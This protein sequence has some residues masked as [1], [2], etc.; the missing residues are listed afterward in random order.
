MKKRKKT[1]PGRPTAT[2]GPPT[3]PVRFQSVTHQV[4]QTP[5][6]AVSF[7]VALDTDGRGWQ[8]ASDEAEAT[9]HPL[10]PH[11]ERES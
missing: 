1:K 7:Y 2:L 4:V 5:R 11:P 8:W 3:P 9:W 10:P 6:G